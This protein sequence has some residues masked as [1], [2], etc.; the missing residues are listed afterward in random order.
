MVNERNSDT[1]L[2]NFLENR[3]LESVTISKQAMRLS[4]IAALMRQGMQLIPAGVLEYSMP[5]SS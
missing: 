3:E 4:S 1:A 2:Q 5:G